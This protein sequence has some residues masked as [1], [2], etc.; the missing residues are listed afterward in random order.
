MYIKTRVLKHLYDKRNAQE[1]DFILDNLHLIIK[2]PD[3]LYLNKAGKRGEFA[4]YKVINNRSVLCPIEKNEID[5]T[6]DVVTAFAGKNMEK[7]LKNFRV[8]SPSELVNS[9][10]D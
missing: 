1:Y 10:I 5:D 9:E 3:K 6:Y 2:A 4:F 7:Y 8:L